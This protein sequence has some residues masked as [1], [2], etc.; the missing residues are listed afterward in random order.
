MGAL[1]IEDIAPAAAAPISKV[2]VVLFTTIFFSIPSV[3]IS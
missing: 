1:N 3:Y 2:L